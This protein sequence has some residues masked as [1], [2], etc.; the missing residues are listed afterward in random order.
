[1]KKIFALLAILILS[2]SILASCSIL[3][4]PKEDVITVEDGYLVVNGVKTEYEV[5]TDDVIEIIDGYLVVNG[6]KTDYQVKTDAV[7]EIIDGYV[8]VD[9][10]KTEYFISDCNHIWTTSTVAPTCREG[11]YDLKTC[12]LCGKHVKV[13]ETAKIKHTYATTYSSDTSYHWYACTVC[14]D[15]KDKAEHQPTDDGMCAVCEQPVSATPGVIYDISAD[16]TYAIVA[17]YTGASKK[18][19]IADTYEGLPVTTIYQNAF[20]DND[21]ITSVIIPDSVTTI[22]GSAFWGCY[23]LTSVVIPDSVTTIGN[24]AFRYCYGI[25]SVVIP[26]SVT[27]IGVYA[28]C[29]CYSLTSVVIPDSVT[30]IGNSAFRNC[31]GITSV[32]I[33]DSVTTIGNYA[34]ASCYNLTSVVI[35]DSVTDFGSSVFSD[36]NVQFSEYENCKYLGSG[37]NP[38]Y[39]LV[40]VTTKNLSSY[41]IHEDTK[42]IAE[43]AFESCSRLTS[44]VIPNS[45]TAIGNYAFYKC[46]GLTSVVIP[47]SVTTIGYC[48]FYSCSNLTSV[49]IGDSVTTIGNSAFCFCFTLKDVYYTGSEAEWNAISI[50]SDNSNL[51]SATKHYNYIP[52]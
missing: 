36:T 40:E 11:G 26:D 5:K 23:N 33:P 50:G 41:K 9:G 43:S 44:I 45:V 42:V 37:D 1:M 25:K 14:G 28:F 3:G 31:S 6:V 30:T 15:V 2:V 24:S 10:V 35:P 8:V 49:V 21:A 16:G 17:T 46:D 7:I 13:N 20:Y 29:Y 51:T 38:Y 4:Q 34:F 22:G 27:T 19:R 48:A 12:S 47:D 18:V 39:Y 52:E 32:V